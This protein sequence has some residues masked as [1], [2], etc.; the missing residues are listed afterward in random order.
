MKKNKQDQIIEELQD[1][2]AKLKLNYTILE[3]VSETLK[4]KTL[5]VNEKRALSTIIYI[6]IY[7]TCFL[8]IFWGVAKYYNW[9]YF[10]SSGVIG[11]VLVTMLILMYEGNK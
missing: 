1:V 7:S 9:N 11:L 10:I 8:L 2:N 6:A 5:E 4:N 3:T